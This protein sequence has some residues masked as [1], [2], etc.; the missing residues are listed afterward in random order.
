M[1][2]TLVLISNIRH[3]L[4]EFALNKSISTH[5]FDDILLV[6]D[7]QLNLSSKYRFVQINDSNFNKISYD[8][9]CFKQLINF[10][11]TDHVLIVQPDSM[12]VKEEFWKDDFLNYDYVGSPYNLSNPVIKNALINDFCLDNLKNKT[13]WIVGNGGFTIRSK[14]LLEVLSKDEFVPHQYNPKTKQYIYGEDFHQTLIYREKL[15]NQFN[16]KFAPME[17]A[18]EFSTE[19]LVDDGSSFGFHGWQNIPWFLSEEECIFYITHL[20]QNYDYKRLN[21]LAGFLFEKRYY[22]AMEILNDKR[23]QWK[24]IQ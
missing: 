24:A 13:G 5:K 20:D 12:A 23:N 15:E 14:K 7:R 10:I 22:S 16:I 6:S 4:S 11:T 2:L 18:L 8:I 21:R 1:S 19:N 17:L 3:T 9:F